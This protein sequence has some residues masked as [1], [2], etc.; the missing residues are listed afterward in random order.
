MM[1]L[2]CSSLALEQR[3]TAKTRYPELRL[4]S[5]L[6]LSAETAVEIHLLQSTRRNVFFLVVAY[7]FKTGAERVLQLFQVISMYRQTAALRR[8]LCRKS[9]DN[10]VSTWLDS[11]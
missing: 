3:E 2:G 5:S 4:C 1:A 7:Q 6:R 9:T 10:Q 8:R 11:F